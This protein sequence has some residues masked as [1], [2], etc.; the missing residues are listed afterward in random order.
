MKI[1]MLNVTKYENRHATTHW[2]NY[3]IKTSINGRL[4]NAWTEADTESL[5]R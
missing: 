2:H 5:Y 1:D 3:V 4:N